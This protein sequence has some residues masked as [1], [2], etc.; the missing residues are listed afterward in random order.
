MA[1]EKGKS[2]IEGVGV[3]ANARTFCASG[4]QNLIESHGIQIGRFVHKYAAEES[5]Q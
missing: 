1:Y 2:L 4:K 5:P 3:I